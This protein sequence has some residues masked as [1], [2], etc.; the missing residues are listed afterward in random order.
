[1]L[2]H[3]AKSCSQNRHYPS[4]GAIDININLQHTCI[5][6]LML[7]FQSYISYQL[8]CHGEPRLYYRE[9]FYSSSGGLGLVPKFETLWELQSASGFV[10]GRPSFTSR[11]GGWG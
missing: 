5:S 8:F 11:D 7:G 9:V 3:L 6:L 1:M 4:R 2:I 10:A